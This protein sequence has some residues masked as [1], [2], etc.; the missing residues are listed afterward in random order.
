MTKYEMLFQIRN[1]SDLFKQ[2]LLFSHNSNPSC[3]AGTRIKQFIQKNYYSCPLILNPRFLIQP[4]MIVCDNF[5]SWNLPEASLV[6]NINSD[7]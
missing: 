1:I 5:E 7:L 6:V 2:T 4:W 3:I